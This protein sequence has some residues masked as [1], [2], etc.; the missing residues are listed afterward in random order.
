MD[1]SLVLLIVPIGLIVLL[2][3]FVSTGAGLYILIASVLLSPEIK[4]FEV[5]D[6]TAALRISDIVIIFVFL[7]WLGR[8]ALRRAQNTFKN[9][10]LNS[11]IIIFSLVMIFSTLLGIFRGTVDPAK[12]LLY[13][14][15]RLQY[16]FIYLTVLNNIKS[17]RQIKLAIG[18]FLLSTVII[19]AFTYF[20]RA[21]G[22]LT[23]YGTFDR[24]T[25]ANVLGG[26]FLMALFIAIGLWPVYKGQ[27][28]L[29]LSAI[30]IFTIPAVLF[31]NSRGAYIAFVSAIVIVGLMAKRFKL[32]FV[33][34][35]LIGL[36]LMSLPYLPRDIAESVYSSV[37]IF[38]GSEDPSWTARLEAWKFYLPQVADSP[39]FG[40]GMSSIPLGYVDNQYMMEL[41][42]NGII[43]LFCLFWLFWRIFI[44]VYTL[45]KNSRNPFVQSIAFGLLGSFVALAIQAITATN[46]YTI[47]TME[48][49]FFLTG[50]IF[51]S[52]LFEVTKDTPT[53]AANIRPYKL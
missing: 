24:G 48:P 41:L 32:I 40:R 17:L 14:L 18:F 38:P 9:S 44:S 34:L 6:R 53:E 4:L 43:G 49:F 37:R 25:Q 8:M 5:L 45:Y 15:K 23:A 51:A 20:Q 26:F 35:I 28:K 3:S 27:I 13:L 42:D 10:P 47:R 30:I 12:G 36:F 50:L 33:S 22:L 31:T 11:P 1:L 2:I 52:K 29:L 19:D 16:F 46:F 39:V 21:Q 7:G